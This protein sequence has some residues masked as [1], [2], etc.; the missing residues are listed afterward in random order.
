MKIIIFIFVAIFVNSQEITY[1]PSLN[2]KGMCS[3]ADDKFLC[4]A[5]NLGKSL[6]EQQLNCELYETY[7]IRDSKGN[8]KSSDTYLVRVSNDREVFYRVKNDK[9]G[10]PQNAPE[11]RGSV[12][13][14]AGFYEIPWIVFNNSTIKRS[15]ITDSDLI[16]YDFRS[17]KSVP[18]SHN[19]IKLTV[20]M[21][22]IYGT[23]G[24]DKKSRMLRSIEYK[25]DISEDDRRKHKFSLVEERVVFDN[26]EG[27]QELAPVPVSFQSKLEFSGNTALI[28]VAYSNYRLFKSDVV[29]SNLVEDVVNKKPEPTKALVLSQKE[30]FEHIKNI[31]KQILVQYEEEGKIKYKKCTSFIFETSDTEVSF[32]TNQHCFEGHFIAATILDK[33]HNFQDITQKNISLLEEDVAVIKTQAKNKIDFVPFQFVSMR[34]N[35]TVFTAGFPSD[36]YTEEEGI[37]FGNVFNIAVDNKFRIVKAK[38]VENL[39]GT[40]G[41]SGS[42]AFNNKFQFVGM[43]TSQHFLSEENKSIVLNGCSKCVPAGFFIDGEEIHRLLKRNRLISW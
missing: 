11:Y 2:S 34:E 26:P 21:S 42:S 28:T 7:Q 4:A 20:V 9:I 13:T 40:L 43:K 35:D 39:R 10:K 16:Y 14:K 31:T 8:L 24:F 18:L 3:N 5:L 41:S 17:E 38:A 1:K 19:D 25:H 22:T 29:F 27:F 30:I 36:K 37:Y 23:I 15:T 12:F 6:I 32:L 33:T